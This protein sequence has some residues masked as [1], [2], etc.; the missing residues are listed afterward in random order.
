MLK[1]IN[2][3]NPAQIGHILLYLPVK[4]DAL[5]SGWLRGRTVLF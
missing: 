5:L 1:F 4:P 3:R 2:Q